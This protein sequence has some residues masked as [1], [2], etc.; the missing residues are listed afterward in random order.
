MDDIHTLDF[1]DILASTVHD[2]KNSLGLLYN[3]LETMIN[4]CQASGC[5]AQNDLF[6]LQYEIRRLNH[7]FIRLL[8]LYKTQKKAFSVNIDY[9]DVYDCLEEAILENEPLLSSR[10]IDIELDCPPALFWTFDKAL[11]MDILDN[12]LNNAYRYTKDKL[13]MSA[14]EENGYL[15]IRLEDNG[16]G[17]PASLLMDGKELYTLDPHISFLTGSTGLGLYFSMLIA[18]SHIREGRTG[19]IK[20]ANGGFYGGGVFSLYLP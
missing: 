6:M 5:T 1:S 18:G 16:S 20:T 10:G 12:T 13:H 15:V 8:A 3:T 19:F 4:Q 14:S 17:Y 2:T 11:V 9:Q 7:N